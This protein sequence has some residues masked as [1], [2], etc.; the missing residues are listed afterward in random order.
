MSATS[1]TQSLA[2]LARSVEPQTASKEAFHVISDG[3]NPFLV[4]N[5]K[6]HRRPSQVDRALHRIYATPRPVFG[7][8]PV[9]K[10]L[11]R[12]YWSIRSLQ[13]RLFYKDEGK[14]LKRQ[15][16]LCSLTCDHERGSQ[17]AWF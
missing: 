12:I 11:A 6:T 4:E 2:S 3:K 16:V 5:E 17:S 14:S 7:V 15:I 8:N 13:F 1:R 10:F 9:D